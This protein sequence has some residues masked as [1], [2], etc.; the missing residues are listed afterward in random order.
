MIAWHAT[1]AFTM[2]TPEYAYR[3][4]L[5]IESAARLIREIYHTSFHVYLNRLPPPAGDSR[6]AADEYQ[7][8]RRKHLPSFVQYSLQPIIP[9]LP[10]FYM[11]VLRPAVAHAICR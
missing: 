6:L 8:A 3:E 1:V 11:A 4:R 10:H 7:E 9:S 2:L 5:L